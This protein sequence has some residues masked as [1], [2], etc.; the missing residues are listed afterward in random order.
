LVAAREL[1]SVGDFADRIAALKSPA[2][3]E[4]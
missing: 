4:D 1:G 3:D 2:R